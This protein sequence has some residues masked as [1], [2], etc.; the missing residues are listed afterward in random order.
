MLLNRIPR[1]FF[2]GLSWTSFD[3]F[4][5]LTIIMIQES[6]GLLH[7]ILLLYFVS[8]SHFVSVLNWSL[9]KIFC[10]WSSF[11]TKKYIY[12]QFFT[13]NP[14]WNE[15]IPTL[16][17]SFDCYIYHQFLTLDFQWNQGIFNKCLELYFVFNTILSDVPSLQ[18]KRIGWPSKELI[19]NFFLETPNFS[20]SPVPSFQNAFLT[21]PHACLDISRFDNLL[22]MLVLD[23]RSAFS[24]CCPWQIWTQNCSLAQLLDKKWAWEFVQKNRPNGCVKYYVLWILATLQITQ[25]DI[26]IKNC[27]IWDQTGWSWYQNCGMWW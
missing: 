6:S 19:S 12:W 4:M 26:G 9:E 5:K 14:Q 10:W 15:E 3:K 2:L 11:V 16:S 18:S 13:R 25:Y 17:L 7:F 1:T 24:I 21:F 20:S 27:E 22:Q 23:S 8:V